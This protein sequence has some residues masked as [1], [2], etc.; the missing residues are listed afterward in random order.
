MKC[1]YDFHIHTAL[2]PCGDDDMT[3]NNIVNMAVLKGLDAIAITDHNSAKNVPACIE[4]AKDKPLVVIPGM[5]IETAEEI[6]MLALFDNADALMRLDKIVSENLPDIKNR[7]DIFGEQIIYDSNDN[8][9]ER[10]ENMLVTATALDIAAAA[11]IV[12]Q[13]GGVAIPAHIDKSSYSIV[14][15]LGF[16]PDGQEYSAVEVKDP[17]KIDKLS[18]SNK[19]D[20]YLIIHNSDAH[21]LWDIHEKEF[22]VDVDNISELDIINKLKCRLHKNI[23]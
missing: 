18:E 2:S 17:L 7:E 1:Y 23:V 13:L 11:G 22:F 12:R 16:I 19:L 9:I 6:H 10:E 21:Y 5:E 4:C 15:N 8:P 14:S 20:K 3:P